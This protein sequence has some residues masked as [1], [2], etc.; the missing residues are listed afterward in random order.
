MEKVLELV[1]T[2]TPAGESV[3][4]FIHGMVRNVYDFAGRPETLYLSGGFCDNYCFLRTFESYCKAIS[5]GR[6][7]PLEGLK[8]ETVDGRIDDN[9]QKSN[10]YP[11][12][13]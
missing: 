6:T 11:K 8:S 4:R 3:A 5:L 12:N 1:S 7:V 10:E 13:R 2:G 9:L